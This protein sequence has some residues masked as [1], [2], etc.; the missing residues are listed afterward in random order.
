MYGSKI[1]PRDGTGLFCSR[2]IY[3]NCDADGDV[4]HHRSQ[5]GLALNV[6]PIRM[7]SVFRDEFWRSH[8]CVGREVGPELEELLDV[9]AMGS[10]ACLPR[11]GQA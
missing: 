1:H 4:N 7:D 8:V 9:L 5:L 2:Y 3:V 10:E 11:W 6:G